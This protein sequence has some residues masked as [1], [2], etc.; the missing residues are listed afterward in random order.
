MPIVILLAAIAGRIF[1]ALARSALV[2]FRRPRLV[3]LEQR[4]VA[5]ARAIQQLTDN[6]GRFLATAEI[7]A[8]LSQV[9]AAA[10][11]ADYFTDPLTERILRAL[12]QSSIPTSAAYIAAFA[13]VV[14]TAALVLFIFGRLVPEALAVRHTE[15][16]ALA[17]V[18]PMQV[19][20]LLL[21]PLAER[22]IEPPRNS[23]LQ[24]QLGRRRAND[25]QFHFSHSITAPP[26]RHYLPSQRSNQRQ[27]SDSN[28]KS[29]PRSRVGQ[30]SP[31]RQPRLRHLPRRTARSFEH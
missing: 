16:I 28:S 14:F 12:P 17:L 6:S 26:A 31:N 7:G 24:I 20:S 8:L 2:N 27:S 21:A 25:D 1:F 4:G 9:M 18:R 22:Q 30:K 15:P 19:F 5:S 3:E 11:A 23:A 29:Q 10:I 13:L